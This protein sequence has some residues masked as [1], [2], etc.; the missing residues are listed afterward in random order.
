MAKG[1]KMDVVPAGADPTSYR[2]GI[3][4]ERANL[5]AARAAAWAALPEE[6]KQRRRDAWAREQRENEQWRKDFAEFGP[7]KARELRQQREA[8][9]RAEVEAKDRE[10][11]M[12][13]EG[14]AA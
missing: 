12:A 11:R 7:D 4:K 1:F 3:K 6:E 9:Y 2:P 13:V 8:Q 10:A 14:D 5:E